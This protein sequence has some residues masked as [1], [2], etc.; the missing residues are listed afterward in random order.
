MGR[1]LLQRHLENARLGQARKRTEAEAAVEAYV[2]G[3]R[4]SNGDVVAEVKYLGIESKIA[5]TTG[6]SVG[7]V[8]KY[9]SLFLTYC[10]KCI[11][12]ST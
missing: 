12:A 5:F 10:L 3:R 7:T 8:Q 1:R 2:H 4:A 11:L 9:L 6:T